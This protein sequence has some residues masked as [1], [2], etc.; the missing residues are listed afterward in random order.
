MSLPLSGRCMTRSSFSSGV[1]SP[2]PGWDFCNSCKFCNGYIDCKVCKFAKLE[3]FFN[4]SSNVPT[5]N[6]TVRSSFRS[7]VRVLS[8]MPASMVEAIGFS[9][10]LSPCSRARLMPRSSPAS[11]T[12]RVSLSSCMVSFSVLTRH[13]K[14]NTI[15]QMF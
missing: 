5:T 2:L 3:Y 13:C 6:F 9:L 11:S 10:N 1:S 14:D 12:V 15:V 4:L 8:L 7:V